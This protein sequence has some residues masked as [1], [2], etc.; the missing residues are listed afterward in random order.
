MK[1]LLLLPMIVL[2]LRHDPILLEDFTQSSY[3]VNEMTLDNYIDHINHFDTRKFKQRYWYTDSLWDGDGPMFVYI[4]GESRG[5]FPK[6]LSFFM[7]LVNE[8]K[9]IGVSLEHRYYGQSVPFNDL[10]LD[11]LQYLSHRQALDDLA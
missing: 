9:A 2:S 6:D 3:N 5:G 8:T 7:K 11:N 4:C 10:T 1:I